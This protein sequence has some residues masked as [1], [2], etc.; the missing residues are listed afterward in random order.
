MLGLIAIEF[1]TRTLQVGETDAIL[2]RIAIIYKSL[3]LCKHMCVVGQN[4]N[5]L[6]KHLNKN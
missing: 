5:I 4:T 2:M 3:L 6:L 1:V